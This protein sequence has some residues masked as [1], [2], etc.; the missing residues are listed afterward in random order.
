[1]QRGSLIIYDN[2]GKIF[3]NTGDAEG[4]VLPHTLPDGLPYIITEFG[5]LNNKI[6]KGIDVETKELITEDIPHIETQEERLKREKQELENQLL[7][8]ADNNLDGGIL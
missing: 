4:D 8:Q 3:L 7:L 5:E 6:V 1:M 2:T